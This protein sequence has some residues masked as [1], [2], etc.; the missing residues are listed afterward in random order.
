VPGFALVVPKKI[1]ARKEVPV[2][3]RRR[4]LEA[5]VRVEFYAEKYGYHCA[6]YFDIKPEEGSVK[7]ISEHLGGYEGETLE[8]A[9][10]KLC[11]ALYEKHKFKV[12]RIVVEV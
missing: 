6:H 1:Y 10:E 7:V 4:G 8:E 9:L 11:D 12:E 5:K 3:V 2:L